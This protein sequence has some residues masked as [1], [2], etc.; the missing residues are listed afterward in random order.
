MLLIA[1]A[2]EHWRTEGLKIEDGRYFQT[3]ELSIAVHRIWRF[4]LLFAKGEQSMR[5]VTVRLLFQHCSLPRWRNAFASDGHED[6]MGGGKWTRMVG[7]QA[8][9]I[10]TSLKTWHDTK[11]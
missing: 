6:T 10:Q 4:Y 11:C 5:C 9:V 1:I 7:K 3:K 2:D 8:S